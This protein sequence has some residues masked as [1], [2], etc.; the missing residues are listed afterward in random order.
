MPFRLLRPR[1][2]R[3]AS[4]APYSRLLCVKLKSGKSFI[5]STELWHLLPQ[6]DEVISILSANGRPIFAAMEPVKQV[7]LAPAK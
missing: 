2:E 5:L 1:S 3:P 4:V 6:G 7:Q